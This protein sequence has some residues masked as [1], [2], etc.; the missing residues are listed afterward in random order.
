MAP[1]HA[2]SV[3]T[4]NMLD[5]LTA[6]GATDPDATQYLEAFRAVGGDCIWAGL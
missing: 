2:D 6:F 5:H 4:I 3:I 1:E